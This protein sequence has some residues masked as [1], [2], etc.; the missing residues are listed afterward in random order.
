MKRSFSHYSKINPTVHRLTL[1][2]ANYKEYQLHYHNNVNILAL[3][4]S[5]FDFSK[6][7]NTCGEF[8]KLKKT[9]GK[10][11]QVNVG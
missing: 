2:K 11:F 10:L 7:I 4:L 6:T 5:R 3:K 1:I 8:K 9:N